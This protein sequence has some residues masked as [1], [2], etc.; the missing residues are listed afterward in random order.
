M[1]NLNDYTKGWLIGDFTPA[2]IQSKDI[3]VGVKEYSKGAIETIHVHNIITEY[4]IV[5]TGKVKMLCQ[6]FE[7]GEIIKIM[8]GIATS[9]EA[10]E[11][12]ITLVIKTPSIPSDKEVL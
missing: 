12:T 9:F 1:F 4:T 7:R 2:L 5:L 3:E 6:T 11:D 10:L 8:P